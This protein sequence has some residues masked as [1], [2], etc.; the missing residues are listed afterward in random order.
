MKTIYIKRF[1]LLVSLGLIVFA[2]KE[3]GSLD[4]GKDL[5]LILNYKP[6]DSFIEVQI[7]DAVSEDLISSNINIEIVGVQAANAINFEGEAKSKY[8]KKG[9]SFYIG[10]QNIFPSQTSPIKFKVIISADGYLSNSSDIILTDVENPLVEIALVKIDSPPVGSAIKQA[11]VTVTASGASEATTIE[12]VN[13]QN[14]TV[15][16]IEKGTT[17]KDSQGNAVTGNLTTT[18]ATFSGTSAEAA[19]SFP[20]GN[21]AVLAKDVDGK[22]NVSATLVPIAFADINIKSSGG[23]EVTNFT[24]PIAIS[25]EID[26]NTINP[27][28]DNKVE[29]G[30]SFSVYSYS[31]ATA[32]WTYDKEGTI[33]NK[34]GKLFVSFESNHLTWFYFGYTYRIPKSIQINLT[35]DGAPINSIAYRSSLFYYAPINY[36]IGRF[37]YRGCYSNRFYATNSTPI[38][39]TSIIFPYGPIQSME[40]RF[41]HPFTGK[42]II[43]SV[44]NPNNSSLVNL[45]VPYGIIAT[46]LKTVNVTVSC[47]NKCALQILPY[48]VGIQY[49]NDLNAKLSGTPVNRWIFAGNVNYDRTDNKIKLK[50]YLPDNANLLLRAISFPEYPKQVNTGTGDSFDAPI[51][52]PKTHPLCKCGK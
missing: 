22:T 27:A 35:I 8:T 30:D 33:I 21:A 41:Y 16:A 36:K 52:L 19:P 4:P 44:P 29:V 28:T 48:N 46:K 13:E 49:N 11:N 1:L 42:Y 26:P 50:A 14:A 3:L 12:V 20:G 25:F 2:C 23:A 15:V 9:P 51:I 18:V 45:S 40:V 31:N 10:F 24:K 6:A 7:K 38:K 43:L 39:F 37:I 34:N 47:E 32:A 17:M 5:N